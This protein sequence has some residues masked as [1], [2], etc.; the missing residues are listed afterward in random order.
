MASV[1]TTLQVA[2][3]SAFLLLL[4]MYSGY[5][6]VNATAGRQLFFILVESAVSPSTDPVVFWTNGG[7]GCSSLGGGFMEGACGSR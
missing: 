5:I 2:A 3:I 4:Q 1:E 6:T 7:P